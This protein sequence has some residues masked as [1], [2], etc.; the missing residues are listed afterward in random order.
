MLLRISSQLR[1]VQVQQDIFAPWTVSTPMLP[2]GA[3]A[4]NCNKSS[5]DAFHTTLNSCVTGEKVGIHEGP[6]TLAMGSDGT[7]MLEPLLSPGTPG[8]YHGE[9]VYSK[10]ASLWHM[11]EAYWDALRQ[12]AFRVHQPC[13][14]ILC[15]DAFPHI[16]SSSSSSFLLLLAFLEAVLAMLTCVLHTRH[17]LLGLNSMS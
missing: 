11:L 7:P 4:F 2:T 9:V 17:V 16:S 15:P 8:P 10:G 13:D 1:Y 12:D 5:F 14:C 6:R 3:I